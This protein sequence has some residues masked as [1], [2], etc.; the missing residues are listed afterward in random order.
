[1]FSLSKLKKMRILK[2]QSTQTDPVTILENVWPGEAE[3]RA[4]YPPAPP[5]SLDSTISDFEDGIPMTPARFILK[6][7]ECAPPAPKK[8]YE[9]IGSFMRPEESTPVRKSERVKVK[10]PLEFGYWKYVAH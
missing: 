9:S 8:K 3:W 6:C 10:K 2:N 4:L 1:M 7:R 5:P